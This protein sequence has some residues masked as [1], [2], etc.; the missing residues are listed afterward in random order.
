[1]PEMFYEWVKRTAAERGMT[2][3]D[4]AR[5]AEMDYTYLWRLVN[6]GRAKGRQYRR[7]SYEMA[8]RIGAALG[9][10]RQALVACGYLPHQEVSTA[11]VL[12]TLEAIRAQLDRLEA[13]LRGSPDASKTDR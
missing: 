2:L 8:E 9:S 10:P 13:A 3:S 6:V 4:V 5:G 1:M 12:D 7:P 11:R